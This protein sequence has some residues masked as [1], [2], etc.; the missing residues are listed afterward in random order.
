MSRALFLG[1]ALAM[2]LGY[3]AHAQSAMPPSGASA[4]SQAPADQAPADQS[5][6]PSSA[7][8]PTATTAK[9]GMVV[10]DSSGATVGT[11]VNVGKAA[12]GLMAVVVNIDG[13]PVS[14][15]ANMLTPAGSGLVS[16]MT[17]AEIKAAAAKQGAG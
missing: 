14:L 2:T 3:A 11:V 9:P 12:N 5:A 7:D 16:S 15:A 10:K 1:S 17:K 13:K 4:P 6:A 8:T